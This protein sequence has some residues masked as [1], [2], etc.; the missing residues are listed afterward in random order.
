[1]NYSINVKFVGKNL[2]KR[3]NL[4]Y[5]GF[6]TPTDVLSFPQENFIPPLRVKKK[7]AA[8][9][10]Q[11]INPKPL[12]DIVVCCEVA[13]KNAR[14]IG[15]GLDREVV[16]LLVHAILHLCG[17]D[18]ESKRDEARMLREQRA[19]MAGLLRGKNALLWKGAASRRRNG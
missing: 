6:N 7:I 9:E 5:R 14:H 18:H 4:S 2:I 8:R 16:F 17:H 15:H 13:E 11:V 1:M 19:L 10:V 3:L 12:G